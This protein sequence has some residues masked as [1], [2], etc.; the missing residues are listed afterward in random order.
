MKTQL[1]E[2]IGESAAL[3]P[4]SFKPAGNSSAGKGAPDLAR[5]RNAPSARARAATGVWRQRLA[6]EPP[7][8]TTRPPEEATPLELDKVFGEIAALEAQF[9][10]PEPQQA[11]SAS[12]AEP[13]NQPGT[14]FAEAT[15]VPNPTQTAS[16]PQHPLFD[17]TP[18]APAPHLADPFTPAPTGHAQSR[19]RSLVWAACALSAALLIW[20]GRYLIQERND[21]GS[22]AFIASQV[23]GEARVGSASHEPALA[24]TGA[25]AE[26]GADALVPPTVPES[27]PLPDVPPLVMLEPDPPAAAKPEQ[28]PRLAAG[29]GE[30]VT[31]PKTVRA[32]KQVPA[33]PSRKPSIRKTRERSDAAVAPPKERR[34]RDPVRQVVRAAAVGTER[35]APP[36]TSMAA[37]LKACREHGYHA[38]QCIKRQCS[39]G[40]YGFACRGR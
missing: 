19:K 37:T 8:P 39:V 6:G 38:S 25:K 23:K 31:A 10:R 20:G 24:V 11:L 3:S 2:D 12:Q 32:A 29:R 18:P 33:S 17:F 26:P 13:L 34:Q 1:L 4:P 14:A 30:S 9:V 7:A 40:I 15:T 36:D 35:P 5:A 22:P 27:T 28:A 21:A 16:A